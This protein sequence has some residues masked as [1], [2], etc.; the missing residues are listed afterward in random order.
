MTT[1]KKPMKITFKNNEKPSGLA[2]VGCGWGF[3]AKYKGKKFAN[4]S[5]GR[6]RQEGISIQ[7]AVK[8]EKTSEDPAPFAWLFFP[9]NN[10]TNM[11]EAKAFVQSV[12]DEIAEKHELYFFD[13][14]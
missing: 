12:I 7:I 10:C 9:N 2:R 6:A 3:V 8:K 1:Q 5:G 14:N 13:N 11:E 4:V